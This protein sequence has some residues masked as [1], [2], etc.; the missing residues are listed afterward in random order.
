MINELQDL[1]D[2]IE[3]FILNDDDL[4]IDLGDEVEDHSV[5]GVETD[6]EDKNKGQ[7]AEKTSKLQVKNNEN[8]KQNTAVDGLIGSSDREPLFIKAEALRGSDVYS[9]HLIE[10]VDDEISTVPRDVEVNILG[11][12]DESELPLLGQ[13]SQDVSGEPQGTAP[14]ANVPRETLLPEPSKAS[15]T[16]EGE[17]TTDILATGSQKQQ[18]KKDEKTEQIETASMV[19]IHEKSEG[20]AD[21]L[22]DIGD[23]LEQDTEEKPKKTG[24][25]SCDSE[26]RDKATSNESGKMKP[27]V[28]NSLPGHEVSSSEKAEDD[29]SQIDRD[30]RDLEDFKCK[31]EKL[32]VDGNLGAS[33]HPQFSAHGKDD[34]G[35]QDE[36]EVAKDTDEV[37]LIKA[38]EQTLGTLSDVFETALK[39]SE[40]KSSS[41]ESRTSTRAGETGHSTRDQE[42]LEATGNTKCGQAIQKK[43]SSGHEDATEAK[44]SELGGTASEDVSLNAAESEDQITSNAFSQSE[45]TAEG[46]NSA[47]S[48][49]TRDEVV[50]AKPEVARD[51]KISSKAGESTDGTA[52]GRNSPKHKETPSEKITSAPVETTHQKIT[53]EAGETTLTAAAT[54]VSPKSGLGNNPKPD[55]ATNEH[56]ATN[57]HSATDHESA[58]EKDCDGAI[59]ALEA[60]EHLSTITSKDAKK[61]SP[62]TVEP[63]SP[64]L[65]EDASLPASI[66]FVPEENESGVVDT[67]S[68]GNS[69]PTASPVRSDVTSSSEPGDKSPVSNVA[70]DVEGEIETDT[71]NSPVGGSD[72]P[73]EKQNSPGASPGSTETPVAATHSDAS[74]TSAR[75]KTDSQKPKPTEAPSAS[76]RIETEEEDCL[77]EHS[78]G[79][80]TAISQENASED[81]EASE[82]AVQDAHSSADRGPPT[83]NNSGENVERE[84][85]LSLEELQDNLPVGA[86]EP[87]VSNSPEQLPRQTAETGEKRDTVEKQPATVAEPPVK[88]TAPN[89]G[90]Q[91]ESQKANSESEAG[92][93]SESRHNAPR[94]LTGDPDAEDGE[95]ATSEANPESAPAVAA[96]TQDVTPA[97]SNETPIVTQAGSESAPSAPQPLEVSSVEDES[98]RALEVPRSASGDEERQLKDENTK[99]SSSVLDAMTDDIDNLLR[100][101]EFVDDSDAAQLLRELE[102]PATGGAGL[103]AGARSVA[104]APNETKE[105]SRRDAAPGAIAH[106]EIRAALANEPVYLFTSLAGGGFHMP[107][108]TNRVAQILEANRVKFTYRDL[109]T[110]P[111]AR[112]VWKRYG[113][114]RSLPAVVRGRDD[115]IGN[116]EEIDEANEEYRVRT[117]IYE[118][119]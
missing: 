109:G 31:Q 28:N 41:S 72:S 7:S 16:A 5:G 14:L 77:S 55:P 53:S 39:T 82:A 93:P 86:K 119:L 74:T 99:S 81:P 45:D 107:S 15:G 20:S 73:K 30:S 94:E 54:T 102:L 108:R 116:W 68:V 70:P 29:F 115:I 27:S 50:T 17:D 79:E 18:V 44:K 22:R 2:G 47:K 96:G 104:A 9:D 118:T 103:S 61:G 4:E 42:L 43:V 113:A 6:R 38:N 46:I 10:V 76:C 84:T 58:T 85:T 106:S 51:E 75:E 8:D 57:Q 90:A 95:R 80:A 48:E 63:K 62:S 112:K 21:L 78:T 83:H 33:E 11:A 49:E 25:E 26:L 34:N 37:N 13:E 60:T 36:L 111:E 56:S 88:A 98:V 117:L 35:S 67:K 19:P 89:C 97:A 59:S 65:S 64:K 92:Q 24:T 105:A 69:T 91:S 101:L 87:S 100:E 40:N 23:S 3:D 12:G 114:G 32:D 71:E 110:D 1:M 66:L 52:E